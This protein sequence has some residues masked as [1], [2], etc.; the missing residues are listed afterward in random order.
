MFKKKDEQTENKY[1]L[2]MGDIIKLIKAAREG[3]LSIEETVEKGKKDS[4]IDIYASS[5]DSSFGVRYEHGV[6]G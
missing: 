1:L 2:S 4:F 5:L 3:D 6:N